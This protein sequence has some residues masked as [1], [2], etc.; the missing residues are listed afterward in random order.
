MQ[1]FIQISFYARMSKEKQSVIY[2][3]I[4]QLKCPVIVISRYVDGGL[5]G[6]ITEN[7]RSTT[8]IFISP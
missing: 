6:C 7:P 8:L 2:N 3:E 4:T 1:I 5:K